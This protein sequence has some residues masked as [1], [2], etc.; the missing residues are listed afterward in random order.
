MNEMPYRRPEGDPRAEEI[1]GLVREIAQNRRT[2]L[3]Y[4]DVVR[5][6][7]RTIKDPWK[8]GPVEVDDAKLVERLPV[9]EKV[10]VRLDPDLAV[11]GTPAGR[12]VRAGAAVLAFR[13]GK[14]ETGRMTGTPERI[15]L[16]VALIGS[17]RVENPS[18]ILLPKNLPAYL[19]LRVAEADVVRELLEQGRVLVERVERLV[20]ALYDVPDELT[21]AVVDHAVARA[22]TAQPV[23][24]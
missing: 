12:V 20:C 6:L 23:E 19:A 21:E 3:P 24:D 5:D 13:R 14:S 17:G 1:A 22:G 2:L 10:S 8:T 4:R 18:V 11:E 16:L 7:G 9:G 15:D